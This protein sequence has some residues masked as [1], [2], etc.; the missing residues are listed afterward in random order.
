M[1]AAGTDAWVETRTTVARLLGRDGQ[2]EEAVLQRLDR[3][4]AD[5]AQA[6]AGDAQGELERL[7]ADE[8]GSWTTRFRDLLQDLPEQ[9]RDEAAEE[10][11]S[12]VKHVQQH[13]PNSGAS[14]SAGDGGVAVVGG[15]V[16]VR[17]THGSMAAVTVNGGMHMDPPQPGPAQD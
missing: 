2:R 15:D 13:G 14:A 11:R 5:L 17:A 16:T 4:A 10:L 9:E 7:R 3:T 12:L 1:T 8:S 6:A